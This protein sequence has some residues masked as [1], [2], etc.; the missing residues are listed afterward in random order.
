[1]IMSK[2]QHSKVTVGTDRHDVTHYHSSNDYLC[3]REAQT[4][5]LLLFSDLDLEINPVTLKLEGDLD[6]LKMHL[7]TANEAASLGHAK[8]RA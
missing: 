3:P 8:H 4:C 1:M 6:I 7:H 2:L 5:A